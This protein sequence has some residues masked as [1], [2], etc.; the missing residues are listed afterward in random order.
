[1]TLWVWIVSFAVFPLRGRGAVLGGLW[2]ASGPIA[3]ALAVSVW[4]V[5]VF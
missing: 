2:T 4:P 1:M 3:F 5:A